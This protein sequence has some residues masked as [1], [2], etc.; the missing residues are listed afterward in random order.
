[1][2][3]VQ[4]HEM[5]QGAASVAPQGDAAARQGE[6]H[7]AYPQHYQQPPGQDAAEAHDVGEDMENIIV[8]EYP[9]PLPPRHQRCHNGA[10]SGAAGAY[11]HMLS[12]CSTS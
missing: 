3:A 6:Y 7:L 5:L 2:R 9:L 11:G 8:D 1:M 12:G 4:L 10:K